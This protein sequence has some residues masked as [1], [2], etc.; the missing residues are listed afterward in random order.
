MFQLKHL[1]KDKDPRRRQSEPTPRIVASGSGTCLNQCAVLLIEDSDLHAR[2]R[3]LSM[4]GRVNAKF[5]KNAAPEPAKRIIASSSGHCLDQADVLLIEGGD[6]KRRK[7]KSRHRGVGQDQGS[8]GETQQSP[9]QLAHRGLL[10]P[11][12]ATLI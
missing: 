4:Q 11:P 5:N 6:S 12:P 7:E 1:I 10:S 8:Q 3:S 9:W 2:R